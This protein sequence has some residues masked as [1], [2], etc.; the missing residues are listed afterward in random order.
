M[1]KK[2]GKY[3]FES[4]PPEEKKPSE[5]IKVSVVTTVKEFKEFFKVPW[6]VYKDD[7]YWVAPFWVEIR[8]FF[9][10]KNPFWTHAETR[11]FIAYKDN[12]AVGRIAAF[13]DDAYWV[14]WFF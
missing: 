4:V 14:L 8:D 11:L 1:S 5:G 13:V 7:E 12:I 3:V 6:L 9:R 2:L 10:R